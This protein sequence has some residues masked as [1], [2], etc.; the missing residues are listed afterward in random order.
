MS[1]RLKDLKRKVAA[2][3]EAL[4]RISKE[5]RGLTCN[6][7]RE[8]G[9]HTPEELEAIASVPCPEHGVRDLGFV[10]FRTIWLP[11]DEEDR[12]FCKCPPDLW[13]EFLEGKRPRPTQEEQMEESRRRE[14]QQRSIPPEERKRALAENRAKFNEVYSKY[15]EALT[16]DRERRR[17]AEEARIFPTSEKST[18]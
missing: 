4:S 13:R 18:T 12:Q 8:T 15:T 16:Q 7:K 2:L 10:M 11:L 14:E 3:D 6:C 1:T 9:F 17:R 5:R